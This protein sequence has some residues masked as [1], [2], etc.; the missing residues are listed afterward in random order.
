MG[1]GAGASLGE[2]ISALIATKAEHRRI[3]MQI[4]ADPGMTPATRQ[5]L[6]DHLYTEEDE[7]LARIAALVGG[8]PGEHAAGFTV[9]SLR[10]E[11]L[12][13]PRRDR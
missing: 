5:Q 4:A 6:I 10:V 3:L 11:A 13:P 2:A 9:G 1:T 12:P 8:A 7:H